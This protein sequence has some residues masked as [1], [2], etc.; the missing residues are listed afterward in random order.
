MT[1][2]RTIPAN[3]TTITTQM[4]AAVL[5]IILTGEGSLRFPLQQ[6]V[7]AEEM[8]ELLAWIAEIAD[9][10]VEL[11]PVGAS[12]EQPELPLGDNVTPFPPRN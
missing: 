8:V 10:D 9:L 7:T 4:A 11:E 6:V 1:D 3:K 12:E 2:V 5:Q